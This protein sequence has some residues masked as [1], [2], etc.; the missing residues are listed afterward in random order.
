MSR[1]SNFVLYSGIA[2]LIYAALFFGVLPTPG[3]SEQVKDDILP[4]IPW[5]TLVSF[6][7]YMLWQMGWGIF[8]FNDVPEAYQSLMVDIKNAKDFLRE[9]G[10]DVD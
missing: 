10:V 4:V 8:N 3:L 7:S 2:T 5:W 6:G 1:F 9:R